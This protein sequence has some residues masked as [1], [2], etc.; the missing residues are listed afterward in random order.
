[1]IRLQ[2]TDSTNKHFVELVKHL[3]AELAI[4]DGDDHAFYSQFNKIDALNHVVVA[5]ENDLPVGCGALKEF[6]AKSMEVKRIYTATDCR[7]K[8]IASTV[9]SE[10]E[11]WARELAFSSCILE[12]G[13]RQ[14]A[15]IKLYESSGYTLIPNYG[16]YIGVDD[17]KCFLKVIN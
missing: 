14:H 6:D 5:F 1:M 16:Q 2:R 3:D 8:G 17:S 4:L 10:L 9:L 13:I 15:A 11:K 7:G 12:T